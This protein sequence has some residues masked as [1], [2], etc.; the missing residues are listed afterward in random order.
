MSNRINLTP[1]VTSQ[2]LATQ[3]TVKTTTQTNTQSTTPIVIHAPARPARPAPG[4]LMAARADARVLQRRAARA[5]IEFKGKVP[6]WQQGVKNIKST[7]MSGALAMPKLTGVPKQALSSP[8]GAAQQIPASQVPLRGPR[9]FG[10]DRNATAQPSAKPLPKIALT[11]DEVQE[12]LRKIASETTDIDDLSDIETLLQRLET[13]KRQPV[14]DA[15]KGANAG[16]VSLGSEELGSAKLRAQH[17]SLS[18]AA[19]AAPGTKDE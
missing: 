5:A 13:P 4:G 9:M 2:L 3:S 6:L 15:A 12:E 1:G 7:N 8:S 14:N 17:T 18:P 11:K 16:Q 10:F 19:A